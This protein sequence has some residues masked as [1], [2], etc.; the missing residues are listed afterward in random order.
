MRSS[1]EA[2]GVKTIRSLGKAFKN[3]DSYQ[4]DRK[5][6]KEEFYV[7]LKEYGATI[8]KPEAELLLEYL[9][10]N[11]DGYVN[12]DEFLVGIRGKPNS[13]R[14]TFIDK[15]FFKFDRNGSGTIT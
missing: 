14:Q 5:I 8:T 15:A 1:L 2:R 6:D 10:L 12:F 11:G 7:G 9:D 4:G 13:K 3:I